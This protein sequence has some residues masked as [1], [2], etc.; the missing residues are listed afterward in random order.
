M[1]VIIS[2]I[3]TKG[4]VG[5][6][7]S[8]SSIAA[9]LADMGFTCLT[10]DTDP[11]NS[12][13]E[14][15]KIE[16]EEFKRPELVFLED[17]LRDSSNLTS[18]DQLIKINFTN[19][20]FL[21]R[22][23]RSS[24]LQDL[25][26]KGFEGFLLFKEVISSNPVLQ[27]FDYILIDTQGS[28]NT[29]QASVAV[30]SDIVLSPVSPKPLDAQQFFDS[31]M[32]NIKGVIS[33][34]RKNLTNAK[35]YTFFNKLGRSRNS[36]DIID[37]MRPFLKNSDITTHLRAYIPE[38]VKIE[39]AVSQKIPIHIYDY[40]SND[41]KLSIC[42]HLHLLIWELFPEYARDGAYFSSN[43]LIGKIDPQK[44]YEKR[45]LLFSRFGEDEEGGQ[46]E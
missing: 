30:A 28:S 17:V 27:N 12:V 43:S 26:S 15:F 11:Q 19:N 7:V 38:S 44:I 23:Q 41:K 24:E 16:P 9:I 29:V 4:G 32:E 14:C 31:T 2:V 22:N 25:C 36:K 34:K 46:D 35:V 20:L 5:K 10:V 6:T 21:L 13:V 8:I 37:Q 40:K 45:G 18:L 39:E 3:S 33:A 1:A 42:E